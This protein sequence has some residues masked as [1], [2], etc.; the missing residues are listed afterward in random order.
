MRAVLDANVL[1]SALIRPEGPPGR[2]A[3]RFLRDRAFD[4]VLSPNILDEVA[5]CLRNPRV[6]KRIRLSDDEIE[7][8]VAGLALTAIVVPDTKSP[9]RVAKDPDDDKYVAAALEG[10]AA[11]IVSGDRH[12]L[13]L[14]E[15][16][17]VRSVPPRA[18]L[19]LIGA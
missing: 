7:L 13:A 18:F 10:H 3:R 1:A 19:D 9:V 2:I 5:R 4:L 15:Y 16:Q 6:R 14:P 8:W 11:F 17:G 12:L